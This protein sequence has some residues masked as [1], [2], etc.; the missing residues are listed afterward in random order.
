MSAPTHGGGKPI[1][2]PIPYDP[3]KPA[4]TAGDTRKPGLGGTNHGTCGTQGTR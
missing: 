2:H 1:V 3:P 4:N